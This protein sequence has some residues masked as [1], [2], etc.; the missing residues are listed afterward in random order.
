MSLRVLLVALFISAG[1]GHSGGLCQSASICSPTLDIED[2]NCSALECAPSYLTC[3]VDSDC[4][5]VD[6]L[7]CPSDAILTP[8]AV[9]SSGLAAVSD[10]RS[11][12]CI[13]EFDVK[14]GGGET[15]FTESLSNC[16]PECAPTCLSVGGAKCASGKCEWTSVA[17]YH[18][19]LSSCADHSGI[20]AGT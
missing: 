6:S 16:R 20:D 8:M 11:Q 7:C 14:D 3:S 13:S 2:G 9:N 12:R 10:F 1:C 4:F 19:C 18:D 15:I 17:A 5:V